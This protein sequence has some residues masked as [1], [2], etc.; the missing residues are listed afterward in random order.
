M[1]EKDEPIL[2]VDNL[3]VQ[4]VGK[5]GTVKAVDGLSFS[6]YPDEVL[7]IV[8]ESGC[9]KSVTA[10]AI[11]NILSRNA[12]V[13]EGAIHYRRANEIVVMTAEDPESQKLLEIRGR[14]IAMIFQ[15]P[16]TSFSPLHTIGNQIGEAIALHT[17]GEE[18]ISRRERRR[19]TRERTLDILRRVGMPGPEE[20]IDSYPHNLSGGLRQRAMIAMALACGPAILIADEPTTALDVTLQAQVLALMRDIKSRSRMSIIF[21]THDLAVI[22]EMTDR[23]IVMYLGKA[24]E[25]GSVDQIFYNPLHP[26]TQ[27]L[28]DSVPRVSGPI[29]QL[30]PIEGTVPSPSEMPGGC[31]FHTRC[32][33]AMPG[34][35]DVREPDALEKEAGQSV[36]CFMQDETM[37]EEVSKR[38]LALRAASP[39]PDVGSSGAQ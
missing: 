34:L 36:A 1:H 23:V 29:D 28:T 8:G 33:Y 26:Y 25:T 35:C 19:I 14:E 12:R 31:R 17:F 18:R 27:A 9:G 6:L 2:M 7:G 24:V 38:Q 15:E 32:R 13:A 30:Q 3:K 4:F 20:T 16:M 37:A 10:R 39:G 11:L 21:I 5:E 22:A